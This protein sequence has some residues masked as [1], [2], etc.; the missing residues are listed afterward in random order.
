MSCTIHKLVADVTL[1]AG[2]EVLLVRYRDVSK[3]DGQ[4]G[5]F[6]PDDFLD[7]LEHP[8]DAALRIVREQAGIDAPVLRLADIESFDGDAWHLVFHYVGALERRPDIVAG[9][10][11][12]D[13]R[14]FSRSELPEASEI[15]HHGWALQTLERVLIQG[16]ASG[17]AG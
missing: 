2:D 16:A 11:V 10:N 7:H 4:T 9:D 12:A 15:G 5:W 6:L 3:Y 13:A 1:T 8:E 14:W 17:S